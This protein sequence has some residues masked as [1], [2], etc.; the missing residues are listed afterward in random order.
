MVFKSLRRKQ[1]RTFAFKSKKMICIIVNSHFKIIET[2]NLNT[3]NSDN[4]T[5]NSNLPRIIVHTES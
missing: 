5:V 3:S 1:W 4:V 2:N